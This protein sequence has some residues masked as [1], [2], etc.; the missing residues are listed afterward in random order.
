MKAAHATT[1]APSVQEP[2]KELGR[3]GYTEVQEIAQ[4]EEQDTK[5]DEE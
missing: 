3:T 5:P 2:V 1:T 4:N